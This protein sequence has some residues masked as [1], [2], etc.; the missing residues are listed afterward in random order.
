LSY[1][2]NEVL[3]LQPKAYNWKNREQNNK[4]LGLIAQDVQK[5]ISEIVTAQDDE[6]KTLGISYIELIP[7]LINAIKEQQYIIDKQK[8]INSKQEDNYKALLLRV[9]ALEESQTN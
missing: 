5:I 3:K 2:L 9:E 6:T 8:L 4:S 7:V 1:G